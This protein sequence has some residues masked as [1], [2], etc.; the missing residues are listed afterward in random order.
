[1][2]EIEWRSRAV[3]GTRHMRCALVLALVVTGCGLPTTSL[4]DGGRTRVVCDETEVK[5]PV[6]VLDA[7]GAPSGEATVTATNSSDGR[8][9]KGRTNGSGVFSVSSD[10]GPGVIK[11]VATLNDLASPEANLT[12]TSSECTPAVSPNQLVLK[13]R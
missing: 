2:R 7:T 4:P 3:L 8:Q 10:L 1:M 13:L 12:V 11:V 6:K 5:V 9:A